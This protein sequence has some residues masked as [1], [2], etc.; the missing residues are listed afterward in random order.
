MVG[1]WVILNLSLSYLSV[2]TASTQTYDRSIGCVS[3]RETNMASCYVLT[4]VQQVSNCINVWTLDSVIMQKKT[5][6]CC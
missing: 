5:K 2:Q 3:K 4:N 6:Q 1:S